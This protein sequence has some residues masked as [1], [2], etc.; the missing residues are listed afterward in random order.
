M[1]DPAR[2]N[3]RTVLALAL[4]VAPVAAQFAVVAALGVNSPAADEL[5]YL[6]F[7][8]KVLEG[9]DWLPMLWNQHNEHRVVPMKLAMAALAR[10]TGWSVKAEMYVSAVLAGLLV[11]V[12]WSVYRS[13]GGRDPMRFAPISALVCCLAQYENMLYGL[14]M[15]QYFTTL[16]VAAAVALLALSGGLAFA[17]AVVCGLTASF[18]LVNGLLVWPAGQLLLLAS[19]AR[20]SRQIAWGL[21]GAGALLAYFYRFRPP[22]GMASLPVHGP[23]IYR[24][25]RMALLLLGGPLRAG[26]TAWAAAVGLAVLGGL[27]L[28][29]LYWLRLGKPRLRSD[30]PAIALMAYGLGSVALIAIGRAAISVGAPDS[31]YASHALFVMAGIYLIVSRDDEL[32]RREG[33]RSPWW[34]AGL[35]LLVPGLVAADL[36]GFQDALRWRQ[37]RLREQ[38]ALQ[39]F[40]SMPDEVLQ[41]GGPPE[42]VASLRAQLPYFRDARLGPFLDPP[43]LLMVLQP[44][45]RLSAPELLVE[46]PVEERLACPVE[47]LRDLAV[48]VTR[49][50][51]AANPSELTIT[52]RLDDR[53]GVVAQRRLRSA[54]IGDGWVRVPFEDPVGG[55]LGRGLVIRLESDDALPGGGAVAVTYPRYYPGLLEASGWPEANGR[56]LGIS[57]NCYDQGFLE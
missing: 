39:G 32:A 30:A 13:L 41:L 52:V 49:T 7:V 28:A 5:A 8:R 23:A 26:S 9:G 22:P 15:C 25:A 1:G 56:A 55:C 10:L 40:A 4:I 54:E 36:Q 12:L 37:A 27:A 45:R 3:R 14:Q 11:G 17:G 6:P 43:D 51:A 48:H 18:S 31:R 33:F 44:Q 35:G 24:V 16:G 19:G 46:T 42:M 50:E 2:T 34:V 21:V 29:G 53:D 38:V 47:T 57:I 20:R